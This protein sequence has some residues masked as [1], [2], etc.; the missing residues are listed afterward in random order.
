MGSHVF[1]TNFMKE[2][3]NYLQSLT[4]TNIAIIIIDVREEGDNKGE[5]QL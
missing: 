5:K 4:S 3:I 1:H 2:F